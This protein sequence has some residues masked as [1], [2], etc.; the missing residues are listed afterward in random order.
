VQRGC[1]ARDA[2]RQRAADVKI[3]VELPFMNHVKAFLERPL[4][5]DWPIPGWMRPT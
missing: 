2:G 4:E 3:L 1:D 5:G